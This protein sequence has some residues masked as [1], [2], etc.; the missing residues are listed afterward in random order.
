MSL[1]DTSWVI[2]DNGAW[3]N[4][5]F[6]WDSQMDLHFLLIVLHWISIFNEVITTFELSLFKPS[7]ITKLNVEIWNSIWRTNLYTIFNHKCVNWCSEHISFWGWQ[8]FYQSTFLSANSFSWNMSLW[9]LYSLSF[10]R[11]VHD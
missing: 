2:R 8:T 10:K 11:V 6:F 5:Y 1:L 7:S 3:C 9:L 4:T